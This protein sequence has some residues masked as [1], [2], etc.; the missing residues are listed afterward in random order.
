MKISSAILVCLAVTFALSGCAPGAIRKEITGLNVNDVERARR[1]FVKIV[2]MDPVA[3][4][5]KAGGI[6]TEGMGAKLTGS[7][8]NES[9]EG[10][11][12]RAIKFDKF[13]KNAI[14]TTELAILIKGSGIDKSRVEVFSDN[15]FLAEAV[16]KEL[17]KLLEQA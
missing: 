16:S 6:I 11:W 1:K 15:S 12:L 9:A 5:E 17:F 7:L 4:L 3:C 14:N 2:K 8:V 10:F 13:Y